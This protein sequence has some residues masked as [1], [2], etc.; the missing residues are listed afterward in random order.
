MN[1]LSYKT[2][3]I[4]KEG[5]DKEWIIVD[6][7]DA[8]VGRLATRV[9]LVLRGKHKPTYTPHADCGDNV[10]IINAGKVRFT[11]K[12]MTDKEYIHH[13]GYPGGQRFLQA[14]EL[15]KRNELAV[16][17]HAIKGMLPKNRLGRELF[18]NLHVYAGTEH[19]HQAQ[20]PKEINLN[21]IR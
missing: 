12:K 20:Q 13:T 17:E 8:I 7:E 5:S 11:G 10:I 2:R 19:P 6:A 3:S 16:I 15:M 14:K 1:T 9:A 21:S 4:N 18:R